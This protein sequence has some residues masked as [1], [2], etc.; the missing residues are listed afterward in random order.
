M[1]H[2]LTIPELLYEIFQHV[3][4]EDLG[5]NVST[6][7]KQWVDVSVRIV[8]RTLY[9]LTP[10]LRL[11]GE[12]EWEDHLIPGNDFVNTCVRLLS[13]QVVFSMFLCCKLETSF[14]ARGLY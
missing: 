3:S 8:W 1:H 5:R 7:C 10:L 11:I 14:T 13:S 6:V 12:I 4:N 9:D 2:A